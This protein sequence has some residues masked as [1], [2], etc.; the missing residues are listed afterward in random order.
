MQKARFKTTG[1]VNKSK[2]FPPTLLTQQEISLLIRAAGDSLSG[3]LKKALIATMYRCGLR[4]SELLSLRIS[5]FEPKNQTLMIRNGKGA[6]HR[7]VGIDEQTVNL[8][9]YWL[10]KRKAKFQLRGDYF[11]F[12]SIS[13]NSKGKQLSTVWVRQFLKALSEKAGMTKRVNPHSLR[14]S[15]T[16][17]ML[18]DQVDIVTISRALGHS[19]ISTT[20]TYIMSIS[21]T[22][23]IEKMKNRTFELVNA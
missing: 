5:D 20:N 6:K 9:N 15:F 8:L 14:H 22:E 16:V 13:K 3:L 23:M 4:V 17:S 10:E 21:P 11:L 7:I 12:C 19:N 2:K 18:K 1:T